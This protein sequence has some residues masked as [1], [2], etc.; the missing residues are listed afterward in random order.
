MGDHS[1]EKTAS[2]T[3]LANTELRRSEGLFRTHHEHRR[4]EI[5]RRLSTT[6]GNIFE[7]L[8]VLLHCNHPTLPGYCG[9][10]PPCGISGFT[11]DALQLR[12]I[13]Q[14]APGFSYHPS[15]Q[16]NAKID[17]LYLMGSAGSVAHTRHSDL[18]V[19]VCL[20]KENHNRI[21]AKLQSLTAWAAKFDVELHSFAVDPTQFTSPTQANYSPLLLDEFYRSACWLAGKFPLW[22]LVPPS[23]ASTYKKATQQIL[24]STYL[25]QNSVID[26]GPV[27]DFTNTELF[28]AG[29][30]ELERSFKTPHKSL[31]KLALLESYFAGYPALSQRYKNMVTKECEPASIDSYLLL[32]DHLDEFF[33]HNSRF[34]Q[35]KQFLR[36]AWLTKTSRGNARLQ[37]SEQ[38]WARANRWGYDAKSVEQLRWPSRWSLQQ[39]ITEH[40]HTLAAYAFALSFLSELDQFSSANPQ[41]PSEPLVPNSHSLQLQKMREKLM[42]HTQ[43]DNKLLDALI[44]RQHRG[45]AAIVRLS[46]E[47]WAIQE[48]GRNLVTRSSV[49]QL[50][51]W[52]KQQRLGLSSLRIDTSMQTY[53]EQIF[54]ALGKDLC[55]VIAN[56]QI[57]ASSSLAQSTRITSNSD[58][59][60]FGDNHSCLIHHIDIIH[61]PSN[62]QKD[63][64]VYQD[65]AESLCDILSHSKVHIAVIGNVSRGRLQ[66]CL[67]SLVYAAQAT[68]SRP[69]SNYIFK[70]GDTLKCVHKD[71]NCRFS[72]STYQ[73]AVDAFEHLPSGRLLYRQ[74]ARPLEYRQDTKEFDLPALLVSP[75]KGRTT[76]IYR[77]IQGPRTL[78]P[79]QRREQEFSQSLCLFAAFAQ[80]RG[81]SVPKLFKAKENGH[82]APLNDHH[83]HDQLRYKLSFHQTGQTW[84]INC[85]QECWQHKSLDRAL[86]A[87]IN[88]HV[89]HHRQTDHNY[90]IYLN[91]L[92]LDERDFF[93]ILQVKFA[94]EENLTQAG[95]YRKIKL[96]SLVGEGDPQ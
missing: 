81:I 48:K 40:H 74:A 44:P 86:F 91:D 49:V 72:A 51:W 37:Q 84:T 33:V 20:G 25:R 34:S 42:Q 12:A 47:R 63:C 11:P 29:V 79:P 56:G 6:A 16:Q 69:L 95:R 10:N 90:P 54:A 87:T 68:L 7:A 32:A 70:Q 1:K 4:L 78:L 62:G 35:R 24:N 71:A 93:T 21:H 43:R 60:S 39:L 66:K 55:V 52:L 64:G 89:Q 28:A 83:L 27:T 22:W 15:T 96:P 17:A 58:P 23:H 80:R 2:N 50:L 38:W 77:N 88:S 31:L 53:Y 61:S 75:H 26:F 8:P 82:V 5:Q 46:D 13:R 9:N 3:L 19:W 14:L 94:I 30:H 76:L 57:D 73:S 18:D 92:E 65:L 36:R 59:L 67:Q 45:D 41:H 85:G